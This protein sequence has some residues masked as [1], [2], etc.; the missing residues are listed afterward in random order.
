MTI[1]HTIKKKFRRSNVGYYLDRTYILWDTA[2]TLME[3]LSIDDGDTLCASPRFLAGAKKF[4]L[5]GHTPF[6][7]AFYYYDGL[8][9]NFC[10]TGLKRVFKCIPTVLYLKRQAKKRKR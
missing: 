7:G 3:G 10:E 2:M 9:L 4:T 5:T 8:T 6:Q 1:R